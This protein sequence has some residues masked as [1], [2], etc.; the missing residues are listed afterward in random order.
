MPMAK[1]RYRSKTA[2]PKHSNR[3]FWFRQNGFCCTKVKVQG[4]K[5]QYIQGLVQ[6]K[7]ATTEET[8]TPKLKLSLEN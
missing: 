6:N 2:A 4:L 3:E 5:L 1:V 7:I 8:N